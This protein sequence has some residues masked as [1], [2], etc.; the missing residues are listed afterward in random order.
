M[1]ETIQ[2][3]ACQAIAYLPAEDKVNLGLA[4][5]D[6]PVIAD[7]DPTKTLRAQALS[8]KDKLEEA[9]NLIVSLQA[10]HGSQGVTTTKP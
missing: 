3:E 8:L 9:N 1:W 7:P 6:A 5:P 10:Q 2:S 4:L